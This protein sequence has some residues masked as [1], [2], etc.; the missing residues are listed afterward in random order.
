[1]LTAGLRKRGLG[2]QGTRLLLNDKSTEE[3]LDEERD[4][5][6]RLQP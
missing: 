6:F 4:R 5:D 2:E 1:M 3:D